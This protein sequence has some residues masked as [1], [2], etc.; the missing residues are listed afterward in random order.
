M[1]ART[2]TALLGMP[3]ILGALYLGGIYSL[4]LLVLLTLLGLFEFGSFLS[5]PYWDFL[6][7][8]GLSLLWVTYTA[9]NHPYLLLWMGLSLLYFL[10]RATFS[11]CSPLSWAGNF[12]GVFYVAFTLGLLGLVQEEYG[13]WWV[14]FALLITWLTDSGA[15]FVGKSLGRRKLAPLLSPKKTLEGAIGGVLCASLGA[16]AFSGVLSTPVFAL[17]FMGGIL[18][19]AGQLGDLVESAMKR[20]C[21]QKDSGSILPGH[22]GI[23]DRFDSLFFVL[24]VLYILLAWF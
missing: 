18:S 7:L 3:I 24:I 13:F 10:T 2:I 17:A 8:F 16:I 5:K 1:N 23:L 9:D 14:L 4:G 11:S 22:G 6:F 20:E 15:Y 19:V 12:L 21:G